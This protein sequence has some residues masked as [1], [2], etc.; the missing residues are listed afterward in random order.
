MTLKIAQV[1]ARELNIVGRS[2]MNKDQLIAAINQKERRTVEHVFSGDSLN[3]P[4]ANATPEQFGR[5]LGT[6][7]KGEA[8]KIR[9]QMRADGFVNLAGVRRVA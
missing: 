9:K 4:V 8:R 2:K 5:Y 7:S 1:R 3:R 6:K